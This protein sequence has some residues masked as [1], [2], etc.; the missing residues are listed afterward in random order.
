MWSAT[1]G[2]EGAMVPNPDRAVHG[3][4]VQGGDSAIPNDG[5]LLDKQSKKKKRKG[6][7]KARRHND[8]LST[9]GPSDEET[10][11]SLYEGEEDKSKQDDMFRKIL[12]EVQTMKADQ[13]QL[14]SRLAKIM[15]K[16]PTKAPKIPFTSLPKPK[17][18]SGPA[19]APPADWDQEKGD[20]RTAGPKVRDSAH[21]ALL[22]FIRKIILHLQ[23]RKSAKDPLPDGPP[24]NI[25]A[26]TSDEFYIAWN[27]AYN[28]L[29]NAMACSIVVDK[30]I[31]SWEGLL[32]EDE[33]DYVFDMVAGHFK[34]LITTYRRQQ[35]GETNPAKVRRRRHC[36]ADRRHCSADRRKRTLF[37]QRMY[38]IDMIPALKVHRRLFLDLGVEG[39]SSDEEDT[40][41]RGVYLVKQRTELS[42]YMNDLKRMLDMAY[43]VLVKGPGS[44]GSQDSSQDLPPSIAR[45]ATL[46]SHPAPFGVDPVFS[47]ATSNRPRPGINGSHSGQSVTR[48]PEKESACNLSIQSWQSCTPSNA[49]STHKPTTPLFRPESPTQTSKYTAS[50]APAT[51][52]VDALTPQ[53]GSTLGSIY[54]PPQ[55]A[56]DD[57]DTQDDNGESH[58]SDGSGSTINVDEGSGDDNDEDDEEVTCPWNKYID[59]LARESKT[60]GRA[61]PTKNVTKGNKRRVHSDAEDETPKSKQQKDNELKPRKQSPSDAR[62]TK[63]AK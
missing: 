59:D 39:T 26:P 57:E 38:V 20:T 25:K 6:K 54:E 62:E 9:C 30:V 40:N 35:L 3:D 51:W 29:F 13:R 18:S 63:P 53:D 55:E 14:A 43:L 33:R 11:S 21:V 22:G 49:P 41:K 58:M 2:K 48:G 7:G 17:R 36:S 24:E 37:K 44:K 56:I 46:A 31:E 5:L 10:I 45:Y 52:Q 61:A 28:S 47:W 15:K 50:T 1:Q 12:A 4:T 23:G 34:Y 27:E 19:Y 8:H 60:K 32:S 16:A 42:P